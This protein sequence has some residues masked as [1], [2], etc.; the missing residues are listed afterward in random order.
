MTRVVLYWKTFRFVNTSCDIYPS[1]VFASYINDHTGSS[2]LLDYFFVSHLDHVLDICVYEPEISFSDHLPVVC[3]F[4][5]YGTQ[6]NFSSIGDNVDASSARVTYSRWDYADL[7]SY[8]ELTRISLQP[9]Y[10][11]VCNIDNNICS[12]MLSDLAVHIDNIVFDVCKILLDASR[13]S[14]PCVEKS[15]F[16]FWWDEEL[17]R[18]KQDSIDSER[19]WRNAGKPRSGVVFGNRN[20]CRLR[21]R[22]RLRDNKLFEAKRYTNNLHDKLINK[23]SV[24]FWKAWKAKFGNVVENVSVD[25]STDIKS[26]LNSFACYFESV[27]NPPANVRESELST[28]YRAKRQT[29]DFDVFQHNLIDSE[30]VCRSITN[31]KRGKAVGTD[32]ISSEHLIFCH[33]IVLCILSKVFSWML[34]ISYV[35]DTFC[36]TITVPIPKGSDGVKRIAESKD[37]RG[38][39]VSSI[40]SKVF[41]YCLVYVFGDFLV[42][43]DNQFG[44]KKH[45]GC[46]DAIFTARSVIQGFVDGGDSA[47]I[48][49]LDISKAFP[50]VNHDAL[51]LLLL[52]RRIPLILVDLLDSWLRRGTSKVKWRNQFSNDFKLRTGV[53]QGSVLAPFLFAIFLD[54]CIKRCNKLSIGIVLVYADDILLL[55]RTR[56]CLQRLFS[57]VE[58]EVIWRNLELN[59]EKCCALRIGPRHNA[60]CVEIESICTKTLTWVS[61]LRYLGVVLVAGVRFRCSLAGAKKSFNRAVNSIF[62]KVLGVATD[63]MLLHLIKAKCVPI[64]LYA[65]EVLDLPTSL[66]HSLDFCVVRFAMKLFRS[67]NRELVLSKLRQFNV[68]LPSELIPLRYARFINA[69]SAHGSLFCKI[70]CGFL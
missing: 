45:T 13:V 41:E 68:F 59:L 15:F 66:I 20:A 2:S 49:A 14:V 8:C 47:Y 63:E 31:L 33:P 27:N 32:G 4:C 7:E 43:S 56:S 35:P 5:N 11:E 9:V 50:R 61:E 44:F 23:D 1:K 30:L 26:I 28:E 12:F 64:L 46:R 70:L 54:D 22:K 51:L 34:Y 65:T 25:G 21:Y 69:F 29:C 10:S 36:M 18:L 19:A 6:V 38:I 53:N 62:S 58:D 37:F 57:V 55:A 3:K 48:A 42:T 39:A 52:N 16:K 17:S 40:L 67:N 24:A 60:R